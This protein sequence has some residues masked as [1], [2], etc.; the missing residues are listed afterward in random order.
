MTKGQIEDEIQPSLSLEARFDNLSQ[1][2]NF[3]N[4][5]KVVD[6]TPL[7]KKEERTSK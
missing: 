6:V 7:Q 3:R 2:Y 1:E 5:L 4:Y